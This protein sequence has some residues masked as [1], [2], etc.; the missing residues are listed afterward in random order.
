MTISTTVG[1]FVPNFPSK[2][3]RNRHLIPEVSTRAERILKGVVSEENAA[4]G[5]HSIYC[6]YYHKVRN[7][8]PCTCKVDR[9]DNDIK[10]TEVNKSIKLSDFLL[11]VPQLLPVK[12]NCP[13]C[14]DTGFVGG[15][16]RIGTFQTILDYT[17]SFSLSKV[18]VEKSRPYVFRPNNETG[19]VTWS[20]TIPKY[21][22]SALDVVIVWDEEP[23]EWSLTLEGLSITAELLEQSKND[24]VDITLNMKDGNNEKAGCYCVYLIFRT[25]DD[26][27]IPGDFPNITKSLTADF[28]IMNEIQSPQTV[29]FDN[30]IGKCYTSDLFIDTR[31]YKTWRVI[32]FE[33]NAPFENTIDFRTQARVVKD[34]E[35]HLLMPTKLISQ[36]YKDITNSYTFVI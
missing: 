24:T 8:K 4:F 9:L 16:E 21:F 28:N 5:I 3:P 18:R 19:S 11:D 36:S 31:Y 2:D 10:T 35:K 12:D 6:A 33:E 23:E 1:R 13:I 15:Y 25:T 27:L 30:S 22:T 7:G 17:Y 14:H 34:F 29:N 32:E 20:V 26:Y